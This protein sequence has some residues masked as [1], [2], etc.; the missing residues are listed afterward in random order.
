LS[1]RFA[2]IPDRYEVPETYQDTN[3]VIFEL[4]RDGSKDS[5]EHYANGLLADREFGPYATGPD[6]LK[7]K[8]DQITTLLSFQAGLFA[9]YQEVARITGESGNT[10]Q[11]TWDVLALIPPLQTNNKNKMIELLRSLTHLRV[12]YPFIL[13]VQLNFGSVVI[14]PEGIASFFAVTF[15]ANK[16]LRDGLSRLHE[17]NT[18]VFIADIGD[19]TTDVFTVQGGKAVDDTKDTYSIGG[20]NIYQQISKELR[21]DGWTLSDQRLID[22]VQAG[23]FLDGSE[24]IDIRP[25]IERVKSKVAR[26]LRRSIRKSFESNMFDLSDL[27]YLLVVGGGAMKS[28]TTPMGDHLLDAMRELSPNIELVEVP[29]DLDMRL[30][31]LTGASIRHCGVCTRVCPVR[32]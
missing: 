9:A 27:R 29:E 17:A 20:N 22:A 18:A 11:V 12:I 6:A 13:N 21:A 2:L 14:I 4:A 8:Y 31:N 28:A 16:T 32:L 10:L 24:V 7:P 26:A 3:S 5:R 19:G 1:N 23:Q 30:L 15:N 25:R